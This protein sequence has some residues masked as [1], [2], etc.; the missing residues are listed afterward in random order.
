MKSRMLPKLRVCGVI[1]MSFLALGCVTVP[2]AP[3]PA[4]LAGIT[5]DI[6][7]MA[8][9]ALVERRVPGLSLVILKGSDVIL[10]RGYGVEESGQPEA[11]TPHT[12][13][14][15]G[16]ISKQFLA[17][18]VLRLAEQKRLSPDDAVTSYVPE[19]AQLP[20]SLKIRHLLAQT[21][22]I[23]EPFTMPEYQAGIEDLGR[24]ADELVAILRRAPVDFKPNARWSYSNANYMILALIVERITGAPYEQ[25]LATELFQP[26][27]LSSLR[28]CTP[29][30]QGRGEARGHVLRRDRVTPAAPENMNWIRG[31]GGLCG[32]ALDVAT[33]FRMLATG[34]VIGQSSYHAM[35]APTQLEDGS[36][37]DYGFGLALVPLDGRSKVAHGG[38]MLGFSASA[39]YY[40]ETGLTVVVLTNR[41]DVRTDSVE[42]SI[43]RR[44]LDL[45]APDFRSHALDLQEMRRYVGTYDI[46]VFSV[47]VVERDGHLWLE[48]PPPGPK[49]SLRYLGNDTFVGNTDPD[50]VRVDFNVVNRRIEGL[51][52]FMGAMHWYTP[53]PQ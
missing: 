8:T 32:N 34:Q 29:L 11:V 43:A 14:Q 36:T 4:D 49:T 16:S 12:V 28:H 1:A 46:G 5:G 23:R 40:P 22:G 9:A 17:A 51:R 26:L 25:V 41:G 30:P 13:F 48:A 21:S 45:P 3:P 7:S 31:D 42:R 37:A 10:A 38:A 39:A 27:G 24:R 15:L 47:N 6:D 33:W 44:L 18:L 19:F 52:L 53:R 50:A 35:S 20:S 2:R